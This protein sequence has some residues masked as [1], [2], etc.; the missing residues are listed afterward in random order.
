MKRQ[1]AKTIHDFMAGLS[2]D[3]EFYSK[4]TARDWIIGCQEVMKQIVEGDDYPVEPETLEN[5]TI[6]LTNDGFCNPRKARD[7]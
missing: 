5:G 6:D 1:L 4:V 3:D 2:I 7:E